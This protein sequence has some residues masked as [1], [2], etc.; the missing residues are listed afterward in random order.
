MP[1]CLDKP[2]EYAPALGDCVVNCMKMHT[3]W[4]YPQKMAPCMVYIYMVNLWLSATKKILCW[5][6]GYFP[7]VTKS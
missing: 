6:A 1:P 2:I 5:L 4:D 7:C 3:V